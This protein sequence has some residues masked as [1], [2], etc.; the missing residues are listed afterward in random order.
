M[1]EER[2][3][4][5]RLIVDAG[6][7][8]LP[9]DLRGRVIMAAASVVHEGGRASWLDRVWYSTPWRVAV[10]VTLLALSLVNGIRANTNSD[11][12]DSFGKAAYEAAED[13][14]YVAHQLGLSDAN[15]QRLGDSALI[16]ASRSARNDAFASKE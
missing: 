5:E 11:V 4:M 13:A 16:T 12:G 10:A 15:S 8:E 7:V 3:G 14:Y 9:D 1:T 2:N 6:W